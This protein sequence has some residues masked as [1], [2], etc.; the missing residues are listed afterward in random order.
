MLSACATV[1]NGHGVGCCRAQATSTHSASRGDTQPGRSGMGG[2]R[3]GGGPAPAH[4]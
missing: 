2:E 1:M 3:V 4:L